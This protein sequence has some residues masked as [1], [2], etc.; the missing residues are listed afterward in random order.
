MVL[1]DLRAIAWGTR[2]FQIARLLSTSMMWIYEHDWLLLRDSRRRPEGILEKPKRIAKL[3]DAPKAESPAKPLF[4]SKLFGS[5][6]AY[7]LCTLCV[8][9]G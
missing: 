1:T 7:A 2:K 6:P 5:R 9:C 4:L 3:W 8:L